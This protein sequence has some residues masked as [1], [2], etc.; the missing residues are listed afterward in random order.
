MGSCFAGL[1]VVSGAAGAAAASAAAAG[2]TGDV[3]DE[4]RNNEATVMSGLLMTLTSSP[5]CFEDKHPTGGEGRRSRHP[6]G[7]RDWG[8]PP[9]TN[10]LGCRQIATRRLR[11]P[12]L[13]NM[14]RGL[15]AVKL[16][17]SGKRE[18]KWC[19]H[20]PRAALLRKRRGDLVK[21]RFFW[22]PEGLSGPMANFLGDKYDECST[23]AEPRT[24]GEPRYEG[25]ARV[26]SPTCG[27]VSLSPGGR[28]QEGTCKQILQCVDHG[29]ALVG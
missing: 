11:Q 24:T 23:D 25:R 13:E 26:V 27:A 7:Q 15:V 9:A 28:S 1:G 5:S 10:H 14:E 22:G 6:R 2:G 12:F 16:L 20:N 8:T 4:K 18:S 19:R 29:L 21:S 3:T 17:G